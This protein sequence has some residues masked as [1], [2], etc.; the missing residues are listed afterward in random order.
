MRSGNSATRQ[1]GDSAKGI[2]IFT[3]DIVAGL[4]LVVPAVGV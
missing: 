1:L 3:R 2:G 4:R